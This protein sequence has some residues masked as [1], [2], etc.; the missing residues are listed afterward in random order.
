MSIQIRIRSAEMVGDSY[1]APNNRESCF[2]VEPAIPEPTNRTSLGHEAA[3]RYLFEWAGVVTADNKEKEAFVKELY[4]RHRQELCSY[5]SNKFGIDASDAEDIVQ[6][7]FAR[8][9]EMESA[10]TIENPR[11]FL[12]KASSNIAI[13]IKR[14]GKVTRSY[15]DSMAGVSEEADERE[16]PARVA[17]SRE[18]LG[19]ISAALWNMPGKRRQLLLMSRFD[20]LSYAEIARRVGLSETVVR[21]HISKAL[22]DCHKALQ[23]KGK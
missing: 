10:L 15:S 8:F 21:K 9:A 22:A 23:A 19:L 6:S 14:H 5:I 3:D 7:A 20:G 13:D 2:F 18:R 12:Y 16:D 4:L 17:E 1:M 11:A